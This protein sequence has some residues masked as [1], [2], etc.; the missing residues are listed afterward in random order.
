MKRL[1]SSQREPIAG[2]DRKSAKRATRSQKASREGSDV[3]GYPTGRIQHRYSRPPD[4]RRMASGSLPSP[5]E[6]RRR[7]T[8]ALTWRLLGR[9]TKSIPGRYPANAHAPEYP[10]VPS[11]QRQRAGAI[12]ELSIRWLRVPVPS[13][14]LIAKGRKSLTCDPW[15]FRRT[16]IANYVRGQ[17]GHRGD[18]GLATDQPGSNYQPGRPASAGSAR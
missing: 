9:L 11:A 12:T 5:R 10:A 1:Y 13:P 8:G 6:Q 15:R 17:V 2:G 4:L 18:R 16:E 7:R 14:S 3:L